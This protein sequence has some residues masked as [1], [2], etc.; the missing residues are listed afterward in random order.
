MRT[1]AT[2]AGISRRST[3]LCVDEDH[4]GLRLRKLLLERAGYRVLL[5]TS[6]RMPLA[7]LRANRVDLVLTERSLPGGLGKTSLVA[8]MKALKPWVPL[9]VYSADFCA[10]ETEMR[11]ADRFI[12]KLVSVEELL[13]IIKT[14]LQTPAS[15][16]A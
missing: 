7:M 11:L 1:Q 2:P 5:A 16:A 14:L 4:A 6:A 3:I 10:S 8:L 13:S 15:L 12:S 9:A